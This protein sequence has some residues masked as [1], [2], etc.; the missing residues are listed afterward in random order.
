[1]RAAGVPTFSQPVSRR[2]RLTRIWRDHRVLLRGPLEGPARLGVAEGR[3]SFLLGEDS[4]LR[5]HIDSAQRRAK[6]SHRRV[7]VRQEDVVSGCFGATIAPAG[8]QGGVKSSDC[9]SGSGRLR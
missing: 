4:G 6:A 5:Q 3:T 1:M 8:I 7:A 9:R 2:A